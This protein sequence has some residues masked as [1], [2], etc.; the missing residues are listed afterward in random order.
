VSVY[1]LASDDIVRD[2]AIDSGVDTMNVA[3][4]KYNGFYI[5]STS[6]KEIGNKQCFPKVE[7]V[8]SAAS[9][10]VTQEESNDLGAATLGPRPANIPAIRA[11]RS[12]PS[13]DHLNLG[14]GDNY[15][16][17]AQGIEMTNM[18]QG[19]TIFSITLLQTKKSNR[20]RHLH[21]Y[22]G[23]FHDS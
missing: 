19:E 17:Q 10:G 15:G 7:S 4:S 14:D 1:S 13:S 2:E 21:R 5:F 12:Y 22:A 16:E 3:E 18:G 9:D 23:Y 6:N 8:Y 11:T 20:T